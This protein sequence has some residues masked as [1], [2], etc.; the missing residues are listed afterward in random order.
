MASSGWLLDLLALGVVVLLAAVVGGAVGLYVGYRFSVNAYF[1]YGNED[2]MYSPHLVLM[3]GAGGALLGG[4][5][6]LIV[7]LYRNH[8]KP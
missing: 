6:G 5:S 7:A 2:A 8:G 4:V 1:Y 3:F